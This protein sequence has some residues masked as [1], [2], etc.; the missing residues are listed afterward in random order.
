MVWKLEGVAFVGLFD[1]QPQHVASSRSGVRCATPDACVTGAVRSISYASSPWRGAALIYEVQPTESETMLRA[2]LADERLI[3]QEVRGELEIVRIPMPAL[4]ADEAGRGEP[5]W[6]TMAGLDRRVAIELRPRMEGIREIRA[7][8]D[9][10]AALEFG[11]LEHLR[12]C[13]H[14]EK[15]MAAAR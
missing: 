2:R 5:P 15:I 14:L 1:D 10:M 6:E 7:R 13:E 12:P 11:E 8:D 4:K 3:Y 9:A